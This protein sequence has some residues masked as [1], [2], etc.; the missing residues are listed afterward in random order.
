MLIDSSKIQGLGR[1]VRL[2]GVHRV[3]IHLRAELA[4]PTEQGIDAPLRGGQ[5]CP[6]D[7]Q[8]G[9]MHYFSLS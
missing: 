2:V 6:Q 4:Q 7:P 1:D 3:Q 8:V 5:S 9:T